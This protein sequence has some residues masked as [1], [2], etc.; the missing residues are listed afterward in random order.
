MGQLDGKIAIVT[1]ATSGIGERIAEVFVAEGARV[2]AAG[3][4]TDQGE[5]LAARCG[6]ALSFVRADVSKEVDVKAMI[7][8]AVTRFGR[9]DCLVNNAGSG[10]PMVS[11]ADVTEEQ[12]HTVFGVNVLGVMLC[13]K[14]AAPI[15]LR[16]GAGSLITVASVSG[17]RAGTAG[18]VYSS[19][20][21][22]AIRLT[23]SA[24]AEL[25]QRGIRANSI[26]PGGIV[27]GIFAKTAGVGGADA[28]RVL[29][30]VAERFKTVQPIPRAGETDDIANAAVFLA[31]DASTFITGQDLAVCGG[32]VPFGTA[33]WNEAVALRQELAGLVRAELAKGV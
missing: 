17:L 30:V 9:L 8:H 32:L 4:R 22:A 5:A 24:A 11:I 27:T 19:S 15:M 3:R 21:A 6:E 33:G 18:H 25:S 26:S 14:H 20:K 28:D 16:Q 29:G 13:I 10:A 7:D 31:S 23:R 2:I 12:F 1:G